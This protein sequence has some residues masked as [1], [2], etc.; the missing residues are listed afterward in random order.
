[1]KG[2]SVIAIEIDK[3]VIDRKGYKRMYAAGKDFNIYPR[4]I[5]YC[6]VGNNNVKS[7]FSKNDVRRYRFSYEY[8]IQN[9]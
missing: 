3:N 1:M 9:I 2:K 6:C 5:K 4:L 8:F 7:E